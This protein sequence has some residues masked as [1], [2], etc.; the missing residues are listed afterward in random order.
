MN[1]KKISDYIENLRTLLKIEKDADFKQYREKTINTSIA[2]RV[3]EGVC[4]YPVQTDGVSYDF[5]E[6]LICEFSRIVSVDNAHT[7]SSG[8]LVSIFSNFG[9]NSESE[10]FVNAVV[11]R[12][13]NNKMTVTLHTKEFPNWLKSGKIGIQLLFD[14]N[15][16]NEMEYALVKLIKNEDETIEQLKNV[17]IGDTPPMFDESFQVQLSVLNDSQNFALNKLRSARQVALVHGPPGTGKTTTLVHSIKHILKSERQVLVCAPSNAAVDLLAV[18]LS[19]VGLT[20]VRIG[21]PARV[22]EENLNLTLDMRISNHESYS[23]L[24]SLKKQAMQIAQKAGKFRR[25]FGDTERNERRELYTE[26]RQLRDETAQ[27][28]FFITQ[29]ILSEAQVIASTLVGANNHTLKGRTY[30]TVFLDEASQALEPAAWIPILK[31][32]RVI[33]AGDHLQLPPT[34]KSIEAGKKGLSETLFEKCMHKLPQASVLLNVQYRMNELIMNF[35]NR[36]FYGNK[37]LADISVAHHK[38]FND[39]LVLEFIDTAGCGF[40]EDIHPQTLSTHNREEAELLFSHFEKYLAQIEYSGKIKS[41]S[42]IGVITPYSAQV[43]VLKEVMQSKQ[44]PDYIVRKTVVNT[45]DSFQGQERDVIYISLVRS[46]NEGAVGFLADI[47]RMNVAMTRAKKKLVVIGDS[48]TI[49]RH[50]FYDKFLE[51]INEI[52]AY[53][54]AFEFLY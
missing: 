12:V 14:E 24:K 10:V 26:A 18:K 46:N 3:K 38:L 22:T 33:F 13:K 40:T 52:G 20:V 4:W 1:K 39:D 11:N 48:S 16:Y 37:L 23:L 28:E 30:R 53:R 5:G 51:Y 7:F 25:N 47:R 19:E 36:F 45:V 42:N 44:F 49:T 29:N 6:Q 34:V 2:E 54:S 8:S 17:L 32:E 50:P 21:H 27:L 35:S 43:S 31:A 9:S 15:T 41:L